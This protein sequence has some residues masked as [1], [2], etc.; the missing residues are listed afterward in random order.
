[1]PPK[2][3]DQFL[4]ADAMVAAGLADALEPAQA[5]PDAIATLARRALAEDRPTVRAVQAELV[6]RPHPADVLGPLLDQVARTFQPV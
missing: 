2:G 4:N 3:A 5:T 6:A 1:M